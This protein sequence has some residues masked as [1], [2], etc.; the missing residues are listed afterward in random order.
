MATPFETFVNEELPKR[1]STMADPTDTPAGLV[2]MTTGVGLGVELVDPAMAGMQGMSAYEIA[3]QFGF[4]GTEEAWLLFLKGA[5]GAPGA[6]GPDGKSGAGLVILGSLSNPGLLPPNGNRNGDCFIITSKMYVWDGHGWAEV[7][8]IGPTGPRGL[9]GVKG[10]T[11]E[12]GPK[13]DTGNQGLKGDQGVQGQQGVQGIQGD[14]GPGVSI[15]GRLSNQVDL[16]LTGDA[17]GDGY[18]IDGHFWG[19]TGDAWV[20]CGPVQ[21]PKGDQGNVGPQGIQGVI[22]PKGDLG[23]EGDEGPQG[24]DGPEGPQGIQGEVGD[25][26]P[27]GPI[28]Q[29]G[30]QGRGVAIDGYL[31]NTSALPTEFEEGDAYVVGLNLFVAIEGQFRD[32]GLFRGPKGDTGNQGIQGL[33]GPIGV[34]GL[35]GATGPKGD[36]GLTGPRGDTGPQGSKG[37]HAPTI[38]LKGRFEDPIQLPETGQ[39][40]DGY[41][42]GQNVWAWTG[43]FFE[44]LGLLQGPQGEEGP[45]GPR[46]VEGPA[47]DDG[48]S[49]YTIAKNHGYQGTEDEWILSLKGD[50]GLQGIKGDTGEIGPEGIRGLTGPQGDE[51]DMGPGVSILGKLANTGLLP[52]T[53]T[54]GNGY[55][56]D[57]HFWGWTGAAYEDLGPVQGPRGNKGETGLLG[58]TGAQGPRGFSGDQGPMGP[59]GPRG[60]TGDRGEKGDRGGTGIQGDRGQTGLQGIQGPQGIKGDM[61]AGVK[62]L[63]RFS[64]S[65]SL[66][67]TGTLGEGYLVDGNFWGWTGN[68]YD[69][70]GPVQGPK[71]DQGL[72]GPQGV[73]G[74]RGIQ[75]LPGNIGP[76]GLVGPVGPIGQGLTFKGTLASPSLLPV[77]NVGN[78]WSYAINGDLYVYTSTQWVNTGSVEGPSA[79]DLF[80]EAN[81]DF[82]GDV[83][84][85]LQSLN[86]NRW[87]AF[88]R[89]PSAFDGYPGDFFL[90]GSDNS[91]YLKIDFTTWAPMGYLGGGTV[92]EAPID[93]E[94]YIRKDGAWTVLEPKVGE[95]PAD[96]RQYTRK[97]EGWV[98]L[99]AEVEEAPQNHQ[100]Y[101]R[102][103]GGWVPQ[104]AEVEE[105]PED[106][107]P[108]VRKDGNWSLQVGEVENPP[109][110]N[111]DKQY[112]RDGHK[113]WVEIKRAVADNLDHGT[114][115]VLSI[116]T[117]KI[118]HDFLHDELGISYDSALGD[119]VLDQGT[120]SSLL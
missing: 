76:Q 88:N 52:P 49:A 104:T 5:D 113:A 51:G 30:P 28:G 55:L 15:L 31:P 6:R 43:V 74:E 14:M 33:Q 97:D 99:T 2:P 118:L 66:P 94:Q 92:Y 84:D 100:P 93:G 25:I 64:S 60:L 116:V 4:V 29:T 111:P 27:A 19:W 102:L 9:Q 26:G 68:S 107:K 38:T 39:L 42:I 67:S 79:W 119:W 45:Q 95:A 81:P 46:G 103:D 120:V 36:R 114:T 53:G 105:A 96:G 62:I 69:N 13:G 24:I 44:D 61:G 32:L 1:I 117:P 40:G 78:G 57:G 54:L 17:L 115:D 50:Q 86:G 112:V 7:S 22:G 89:N 21:G 87:I 75:G 10:E 90:N 11:G 91:W 48:L 77:E 80:Q 108:Y 72:Q 71:G 47:S 3:V 18:L 56:I 73:Q 82:P 65:G 109:A 106:G 110:V 98:I 23:P 101:V 37:D 34:I 70:L 8:Q 35:T 63:G 12:R 16:P 85:W 20:D 83:T 41:L 59:Q 58:P